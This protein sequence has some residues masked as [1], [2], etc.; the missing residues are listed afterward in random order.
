ME[1]LYVHLSTLFICQDDFLEAWIFYY[2]MT[3]GDVCGK[4]KDIFSNLK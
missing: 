3:P 1:E 4:N 2:L